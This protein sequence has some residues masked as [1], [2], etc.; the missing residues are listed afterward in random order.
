MKENLIKLVR[1]L[2]LSGARDNSGLIAEIGPRVV[3]LSGY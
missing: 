2:V 3:K 1:I